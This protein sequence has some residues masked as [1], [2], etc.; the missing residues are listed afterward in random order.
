MRT[1]VCAPVSFIASRATASRSRD[2]QMQEG[3]QSL[4]MYATSCA[5][6]DA[7]TGT[8]IPPFFHTEKKAY[9]HP[10]RFS[11]NISVLVSDPLGVKPA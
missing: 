9:I 5:E 11:L 8:G 1:D 6:L 3:L 2:T 7:S 4:I 10:L